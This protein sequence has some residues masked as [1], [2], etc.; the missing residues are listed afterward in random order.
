[1][2]KR[3]LLTLVVILCAVS[4]AYAGWIDWDVDPIEIIDN[5]P[6]L[7]QIRCERTT[8]MFGRDRVKAN[9]L[10]NETC[11][12]RAI[13]KNLQSYGWRVY[14][15]CENNTIREFP[16]CWLVK[17]GDKLHVYVGPNT[18][19]HGRNKHFNYELLVNLN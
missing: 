17:D 1:M 19:K 3:V 6:Y 7:T 2:I 8:S 16:D 5:N 15:T 9:Y 13:V 18:H 11:A 4:P 10:F 14:D 12:Y